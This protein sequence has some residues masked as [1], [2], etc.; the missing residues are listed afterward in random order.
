METEVLAAAS[1]ID[2]SLWALFWRATFVVKIVMIM[3]F[4]ASIWVWAILFQK[5]VQ[6][7]RA[8]G[9][10]AAFD[11]AFWSGEPLDELYEKIGDT[12]RSASERIFVAAMGEWNRSHRDDGGLIAGT[13]A[14]IDRTMDVAISK[15]RDRLAGGLTFLATVGSTAPFVGLF[16][17]VWGIK[18]AFEQIALSGSTNLAVVAPGI[19]EA[20]L[21]TG[22]GLV[23]AI[24][25]V[26][27]YNKLSRDADRITGNFEAFADEFATILSRQL[28]AA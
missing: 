23:A 17:T 5:V 20:L 9:N 21:A 14:R 15:E 7:R 25:A 1:E 27:F 18:H 3:L 2:F 16:G 26:V 13:Q 24:P 10:A 8:R 11:R 4:A 28:D 6:F 22:I 12:P 19:A